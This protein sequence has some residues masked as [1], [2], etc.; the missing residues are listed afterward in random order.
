MAREDQLPWQTLS[1]VTRAAQ[2]FLDPVLAG[3]LDATWEPNR[4]EWQAQ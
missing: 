2:N 4:R 1:E 3:N